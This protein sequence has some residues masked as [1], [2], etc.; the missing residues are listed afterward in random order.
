MLRGAAIGILAAQWR[1]LPEAGLGA[2]VE[3]AFCDGRWGQSRGLSSGGGR[4]GQGS[5]E[6]VEQDAAVAYGLGRGTCAR[7][8][9]VC[10]LSARVILVC[11]ACAWGVCTAYGHCVYGWGLQI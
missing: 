11:G 3:A 7:V 9:C 8:A 2:G 1:L 10:V 4:G 5:G 6:V